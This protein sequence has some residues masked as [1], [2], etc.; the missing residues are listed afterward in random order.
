[1]VQL[2]KKF[3]FNIRLDCAW[4]LRLNS[5]PLSGHFTLSG[6]HRIR[7]SGYP[8]FELVEKIHFATYIQLFCLDNQ[9][10]TFSKFYCHFP[11]LFFL[12]WPF[13]N[14]YSFM[15]YF[16]FL[17][18]WREQ[19]RWLWSRS[20]FNHIILNHQGPVAIRET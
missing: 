8:P 6:G 15:L 7:T 11:L 14:L 1:M 10:W 13:F 18:A 17:S 19:M 12:F 20:V 2:E 5:T 16:E 9:I 3:E 4:L